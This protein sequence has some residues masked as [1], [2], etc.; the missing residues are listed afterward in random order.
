MDF[1]TETIGF[2]GSG[3][4]VLTYW[5]REMLPLR[6]AAVLSCLFFIAYAAIIGSLPL[7]MME[8]IL[9]PINAYRLLELRRDKATVQIAQPRS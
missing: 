6:V 7:L 9:L 1:W 4:A 5:M 2:L 8:T 3:F